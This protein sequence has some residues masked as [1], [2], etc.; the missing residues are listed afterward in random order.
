[1]T[2]ADSDGSGS[3]PSP[4]PTPTGWRSSTPR[5][6]LT[7]SAGWTAAA[8]RVANG[9]AGLGPERGDA[10]RR[11][12]AQR[13]RL[14]RAVPGRHADRPVH[15]ADQLPPHRPRDRLHRAT[16]ARPRRS[17]S[18]ERFAAAGRGG[19]GGGGPRRSR[20]GSPWARSTASA[21]TTSWRPAS[22]RPVRTGGTAGQTMLYTSGTTG[23]PKGVRRPLP[24]AD[25][26]DRRSGRSMLASLFEVEPG[27]GVHLVG[28]AALPRRP[29]GLRHRR[30][31]PGPGHGAHGHVDPRAHARADRAAPGHH[32]PHGA[33]H[34]PPSARAPDEDERS[35]T[36]RRRCAP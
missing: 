32:Q 23:R 2:T 9:A 10:H 25:P 36:T 34:V 15:H 12:V 29:A 7:P 27:D 30:A 17:W 35:G 5:R 28:R 26:N 14:P 22:P 19:G 24:E 11:R 13:G 3:G 20:H 8:N 31:A 4:L 6:R 33:D 1:M 21:P 16:T 18:R